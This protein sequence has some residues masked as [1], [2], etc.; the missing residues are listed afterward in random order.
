MATLEGKRARL[1]LGAPRLHTGVGA[2][3]NSRGAHGPTGTAAALGVDAVPALVRRPRSYVRSTVSVTPST[4]WWHR[5]AGG[6]ELLLVRSLSRSLP[7]CPLLPSLSPSLPF[8]ITP[9]DLLLH[10]RPFLP[11]FLPPSSLSHSPSLL[12]LLSV[13]WGLHII[14]LRIISLPLSLHF[15]GA[16]G[17]PGGIWPSPSLPPCL[18]PSLPSLSPSLPTLQGCRYREP[19][20]RNWN[21]QKTPVPPPANFLE[22]AVPAVLETPL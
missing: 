3:G 7:I 20:Y 11:A 10:L 12:V 13:F 6:W 9:L 15:V 2:T 14:S 4:S 18:P 1:A 8:S 17:D 21:R 19:A 5:A 16:Y 22:P